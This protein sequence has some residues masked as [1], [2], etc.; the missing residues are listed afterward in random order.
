MAELNAL[1]L[2]KMQKICHQI[3]V[4]SLSVEV[5]RAEEKAV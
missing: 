3:G 4:S 1:I 5:G 2:E